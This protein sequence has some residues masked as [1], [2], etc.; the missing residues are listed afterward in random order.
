M[1]WE[2]LRAFKVALGPPPVQAEALARHAGAARWAFNCA[3]AVK[4]SAH[5]RGGRRPADSS[6]RGRGGE[7]DRAGAD[8][9]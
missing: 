9:V 8:R 5:Q 3:L 2:V 7:H 1:E 4:V 6:L